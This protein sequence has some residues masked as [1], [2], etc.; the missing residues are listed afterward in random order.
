MASQRINNPN[1][2]SVT[3]VISSLGRRLRVVLTRPPVA[4]EPAAEVPTA[5]PTQVEMP[6]LRLQTAPDARAKDM[7]G[8][9][10]T[11]TT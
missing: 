4:R 3:G 7:T 10:R 8:Y 1:S 6:D 5:S 11:S 9:V 2:S